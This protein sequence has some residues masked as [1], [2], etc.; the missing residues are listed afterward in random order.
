MARKNIERCT[1]TRN[2][3]NADEKPLL[4]I[5]I[6]SMRRAC[7]CIHQN[8]HLVQDDEYNCHDSLQAQFKEE[9]GHF[10]PGEL[11]PH[12]AIKDVYQN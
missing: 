10:V 8:K 1:E 7:S 11:T 3:L 6:P 4:S 9:M 5:P 12:S 2:K